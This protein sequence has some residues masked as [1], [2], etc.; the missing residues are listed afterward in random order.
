MTDDWRETPWGQAVEYGRHLFGVFPLEYEQKVTGV[1]HHDGNVFQSYVGTNCWRKYPNWEQSY[2][3][4]PLKDALEAYVNDEEMQTTECMYHCT[5]F[6]ES[7][8]LVSAGLTG[9][10]YEYERK[11]AFRNEILTDRI[12][13]GEIAI[14][15]RYGDIYCVEGRRDSIQERYWEFVDANYDHRHSY[16]AA[17]KTQSSGG[18]S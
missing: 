6:E 17:T 12:E 8:P 18:N 15:N 1:L 7:E 2:K 3:Q 10:R 16:H 5:I 9:H 13:L 11:R 14:L 4:T